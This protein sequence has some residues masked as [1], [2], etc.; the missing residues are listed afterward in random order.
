MKKIVIKGARK[1]IKKLFEAIL[2]R[3]AFIF[4]APRVFTR[5]FS[6]DML[7]DDQLEVIDDWKAA[8]RGQLNTA[9]KLHADKRG[10]A[11]HGDTYF[12]MLPLPAP[13]IIVM[14]DKCLIRYEIEVFAYKK[15]V[16]LSA[17]QAAVS[18]NGVG[19]AGINLSGKERA[20]VQTARQLTALDFL[21]T[22]IYIDR[23]SQW[24]DQLRCNTRFLVPPS[25][26]Q[27][28]AALR[29]TPIA[30]VWAMH[31][32]VLASLMPL[33][34]DDAKPFF[35][36]ALRL[37]ENE[38]AAQ[39]QRDLLRNVLS[40]FTFG[41]SDGQSA[42]R[43]LEISL[44]E[45]KDIQT[46]EKVNGLPVLVN[47]DSE[48]VQRELTRAIQNKHCE[49]LARGV[50]KHPLSTLPII[51]GDALPAE[52]TIFALDWPAFENVN[53][54][55]VAVLRNAFGALM[56]NAE[57][58]AAFISGHIERLSLDGVH[59]EQTYL[60]VVARELDDALFGITERIGPLTDWVQHL[61]ATC[62]NQQA[63]RQRRFSIALDIVRDTAQYDSLIA[64]DA[65]EM[66][67]E[68][69]GFWY[70]DSR[71]ETFI[72]FELKEDFPKFMTRRLGLRA[73][74]SVE[75]RR[76]L[77]NNGMMKT[78]SKNVRGRS[79]DSISHALICLPTGCET[80]E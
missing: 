46:L 52:N 29:E 1:L 11:D 58:L 30:V 27:V 65:S 67:P 25:V 19:I 4:E 22:P 15:G 2:D 70:T 78:V 18:E 41:R 6:R 69:L 24:R 48:P 21:K 56:K 59:Y 28:T 66:T 36:P 37:S 20:L 73:G 80:G 55:H 64:P 51:V 10:L 47:L 62:E 54:A 17:V 7:T 34:E 60:W 45:K 5:N 14:C 57:R 9:E 68:Q 75:F 77:F 49:L 76:Y 44:Q 50:A 16:L 74:D 33:L 3:E 79:R 53:P 26:E 31:A 43:L 13:N 42:V 32:A 71:G 35:Y 39:M 8:V 23:M 61:I 40:G 63:E 72:A 12:E 38:T